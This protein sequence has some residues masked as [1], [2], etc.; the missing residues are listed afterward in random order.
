MDSNQEIESSTFLLQSNGNLGAM[1]I[2][3]FIGMGL[4]G[5]AMAQVYNY[6]NKSG[7]DR[8]FLK[9]LVCLFFNIS[10]FTDILPAS[11]CSLDVCISGTSYMITIMINDLK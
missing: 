10:I 5:V 3:T 6:F 4:F 9:L 7:G 8:R 11:G 2:C 1:E